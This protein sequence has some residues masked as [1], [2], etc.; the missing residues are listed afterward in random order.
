MF[1]N[2]LTFKKKLKNLATPPNPATCHDPTP[3]A[4]YCPLWA[5]TLTILFLGTHEQYLPS[6]SPILGLLQRKLAYLRSS[7]ESKASELPKGLMLIGG[8]HVHIR[9]TRSSPLGDVGSYNPS[10][11]G[12][13]RPH[14]HTSG[15]GVALIPNYHIPARARPLPELD[16]AIARYCPLWAPLSA[17]TVLFLG[18]HE[19]LPSGSPILGLLQPQHA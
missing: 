6:G 2:K 13:R 3:R 14:G 10:P 19:Q 15:Q 8:G 12:A 9:L 4:R 17:L 16:S 5:S 18:A 11:L 1:K 7:K